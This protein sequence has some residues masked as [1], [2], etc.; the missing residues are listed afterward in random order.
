MRLSEI[1]KVGEVADPQMASIKRQQKDLRVR[2]AR[3]RANKA[4][5]AL[6]KAQQG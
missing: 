5:Q 4:Q 6:Q 3:L 2:K 1:E